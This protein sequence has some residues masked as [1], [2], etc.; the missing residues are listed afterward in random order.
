MTSAG[1]TRLVVEIPDSLAQRLDAYANQPG[2]NRTILVR[3]GL[4]LALLAWEAESNGGVCE[5]VVAGED[6]V[7]KRFR[8]LLP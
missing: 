6:G 5:V 2:N 1:M 4:Q 3:M 7:E 8:P